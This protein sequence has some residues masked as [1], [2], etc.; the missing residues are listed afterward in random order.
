M[1]QDSSLQRTPN[2]SWP[3]QY[4]EGALGEI[5]SW[6]NPTIGPF[7]RVVQTASG[8]LDETTD[9]LREI[10]G[11]NWTLDTVV[12]GI[13]TKV[14]E[15]SQNFVWTDA[16]YLDLQR[17]G[18]R[19]TTHG[20]AFGHDLEKIDRHTKDLHPKYQ[21]LA[22]AEGASTGFVG[23][24]GI[25]PD[26]IALTAINLRAVGE[27]ASYYGFDVQSPEEQLQTLNVLNVAAGGKD[28]QKD[29][30]LKPIVRASSS[31]AKQQVMESAGQAAMT[32]AIKRA[33]EKLGIT[34]TK[35]KV[36]Q[37]LPVAG[38][39]V[40][41]AFNLAYTSKV[42]TTAYH[43]YRHRFLIAKHGDYFRDE[44]KD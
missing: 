1:M 43:L 25:L 30:A 12:A 8:I 11:V 18:L 6:R 9:L 35:K 38:A 24:V 34:L 10:P 39:V 14:N 27:Y 21:V 2:S 31:I 32:G 23:A 44:L 7:G 3:S 28:L 40:G 41:G 36:A 17:A 33:V 19:I 16:V 22:T 15:A 29:Y 13:L 4:E 26:I 37:M 5:Q 42:C 20:Q